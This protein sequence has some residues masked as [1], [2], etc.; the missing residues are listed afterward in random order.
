MYQSDETFL[1]NGGILDRNRENSFFV[2]INK[3]TN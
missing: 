2:L 3:K 1:T